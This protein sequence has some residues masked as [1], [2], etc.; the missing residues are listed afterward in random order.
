M[1]RKTLENFII[2]HL[3]ILK[4]TNSMK[5]SIKFLQVLGVLT[6]IVNTSFAQYAPNTSPDSAA[7]V[8]PIVE[9]PSVPV[10]QGLDEQPS[11]SESSLTLVSKEWS[12]NPKYSAYTTQLKPFLVEEKRGHSALSKITFGI[13]GLGT[14]VLALSMK[15]SF[16]KKLDELNILDNTAPKMNGQF[17]NESDYSKWKTSYDALVKD[18]GTFNMV[19]VTSVVALAIETFLF[20]HKPSHKRLAL[21]PTNRGIDF[22]FRF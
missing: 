16:Q 13:I 19:L 5:T 10:V 2:A 1:A 12:N 3:S 17:L 22:A 21:H 20:I 15:S 18:R 11:T 14:G 7:M 8:L 6:F 4:L 9:T